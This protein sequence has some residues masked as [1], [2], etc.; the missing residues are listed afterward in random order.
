MLLRLGAM[1]CS[2]EKGKDW[3]ERAITTTY[4]GMY[5]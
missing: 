3:R 5:P 4:E 2:F 1:M